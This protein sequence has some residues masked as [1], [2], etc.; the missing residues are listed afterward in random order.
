MKTHNLLSG[1]ISHSGENTVPH[2]DVLAQQAAE[3]EGW[4]VATIVPAGLFFATPWHWYFRADPVN[5]VRDAR[6]VRVRNS[7]FPGSI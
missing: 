6:S 4:P 2:P 1:P 7:A 5:S 3:N